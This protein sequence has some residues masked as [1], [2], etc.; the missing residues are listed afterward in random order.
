ME[1][2]REEKPKG[3]RR[4]RIWISIGIILAL[5]II[6]HRP[7]LLASIHWFAVR[8]AAKENLKLDFRLEGSVLGGITIRN[9][10]ITPLK[11]EAPVE[12]G[13]A[14][15]I[16]A[17]Y[18]L[19]SLLGNKADL[20]ELIEIR[21]AHFVIKPQPAVKPSPPP[22]EQ[23]SLPGIFPQRVR[24]E[25]VS[26]TVRN[27]PS[28]LVLEGFNLD[29]NPRAS[30]ALSVSK[31]QLPSGQNWSG[32]TGTTSYTDRNLFLRDI[33]LGERTKIPLVNL[34]ASN[35]R[36]HTLGFKID[37]AIDEA[38]LG[39]QGQLMKEARSLRVQAV[40]AVHNLSLASLQQFG[41]EGMAGKV[42]N[43]SFDFSGLLSSPKTWASSG[44][45]LISDLQSDG[46]TL[47]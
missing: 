20:I 11:P 45:A 24:I 25:G 7:I 39:A 2:D 44:A 36:A 28:D 1:D 37:V 38:S 46:V 5:L 31:L 15:Y 18:D 23:T 26:V 30:G 47:D 3:N 14:N 6:F 9:L 4:R 22:K 41:V 27:K 13:D 16:R 32:V 17:E 10:H 21:D 33:A 40:A 43:V 8:A 12:S 19:F 35:I 34:D 29:L 42:E